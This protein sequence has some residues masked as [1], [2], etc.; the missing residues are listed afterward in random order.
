MTYLLDTCAIL[1]WWSEPERLSPRVL[2]L[3]KDPENRYYPEIAGLGAKI[4][5]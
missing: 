1:W 5:W 2:S 3:I 4:T